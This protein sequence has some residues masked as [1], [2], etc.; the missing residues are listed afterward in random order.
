MTQS[1]TVHATFLAAS[2]TVLIA[3][4]LLAPEPQNSRLWSEVFNA[5]HA[6]LYGLVALAILQLLRFRAA[7]SGNSPALLYLLALGLHFL[8]NE[9]R[10]C[11]RGGFRENATLGRQ[12]LLVIRARGALVIPPR[13]VARPVNPGPASRLNEI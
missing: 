10:V 1:R 7:E 3:I 12:G 4:Q 8:G 11:S 2:A 9:I 5:G 13:D 6:P